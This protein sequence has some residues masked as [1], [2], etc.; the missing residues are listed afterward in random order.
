MKITMKTNDSTERSKKWREK[1]REDPLK[2]QEFLQKQREYREKNKQKIVE[3]QIEWKERN[4]ERLR[5]EAKDRRE[6]DKVAF[7]E[8]IAKWRKDNPEKWKEIQEKSRNKK[9]DNGISE[10]ES[11]RKRLYNSRNWS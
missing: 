10:L 5:K 4:R 6:L 11:C 8:G 3:Q 2:Y 1:L 9:K 7:N